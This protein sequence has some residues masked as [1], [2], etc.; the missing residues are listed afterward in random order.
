MLQGKTITRPN[1]SSEYCPK[2]SVAF[3]CLLAQGLQRSS[4]T[5]SGISRGQYR[6]SPS[7]FPVSPPACPFH[8]APGLK[9]LIAPR[10]KFAPLR[11]HLQNQRCPVL[12]SMVLGNAWAGISLALRCAGRSLQVKSDND[13]NES[14]SRSRNLPGSTTNIKVASSVRKPTHRK[15]FV[16][17]RS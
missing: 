15:A 8:P 10:A 2:S 12:K 9:W 3:A 17:V 14:P 13:S 5:S 6:P 11:E 16:S 7:S 1:R 4:Y